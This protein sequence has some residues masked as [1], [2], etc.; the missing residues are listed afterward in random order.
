MT[1]S[2]EIYEDA[3]RKMTPEGSLRYTITDAIN[4]LTYSERSSLALKNSVTQSARVILLFIQDIKEH[5]LKGNVLMEQ[6]LKENFF[7]AYTHV[8]SY[9]SKEVMERFISEVTDVPLTE[10]LPTYQN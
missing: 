8:M 9:V 6:F 3:R 7:R 1:T 5:R 4:S 10:L 2:I